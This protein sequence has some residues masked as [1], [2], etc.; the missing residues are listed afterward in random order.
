MAAQ[1]TNS[2]TLTLNQVDINSTT[3]LNRVVGPVQYSG[4]VGEFRSGMFPD[5]SAHSQ[6]LPTT[7]LT[8][9][10]FKNLDSAAVVT[11]TWTPSGGSSNVV[12]AV[13]P[14]G[15]ILFW[16]GSGTNGITALSYTSTVSNSKFEDFMGG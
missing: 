7:T 10:Y 12:K 14:G 6:T 2:A 8:N 3:V 5:T 15:I 13:G 4:N 11:V 1:S 9:F 16:E